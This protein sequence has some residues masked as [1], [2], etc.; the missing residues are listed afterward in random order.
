MSKKITEVPENLNK[1]RKTKFQYKSL[2]DPK[3]IKD[4]EEFLKEGGNGWW[5]KETYKRKEKGNK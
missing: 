4:K 5:V 2:E 1:K 3:Y